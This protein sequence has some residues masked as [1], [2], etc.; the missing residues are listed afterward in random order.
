MPDVLGMF[1]STLLVGVGMPFGSFWI[2]L[3]PFGVDVEEGNYIQ[4]HAS[5]YNYN[6]LLYII[7]IYY[8]L[9]QFIT[10]YYNILQSRLDE[11]C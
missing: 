11:C 2:L 1:N 10:Y 6:I 9:L 5:T 4:F 3:D 7:T 8:I